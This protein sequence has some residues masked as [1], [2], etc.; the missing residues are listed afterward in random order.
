[1]T[2][3]D[4]GL[5]VGVR[6]L[7]WTMGYSTRLD[8][9]LRGFAPPAAGDRQRA[10]PAES[11]TDLDVLGVAV[12]P[13]Q[14]VATAIADCKTTR[15]DSTSRMFWVRGVADLF[16][17]DHA[18]LVR[19]HDVS[20]AARQLSSRLGIT[21]LPTDDLARLQAFHPGPAADGPPSVLFDR[22]AVERH[23]AAFDALDR[24]LRRLLDYRQFDYWVY[25]PHRNPVQ[26]VAHLAGAARHLDPKNPVHAALFLDLAWLYLLA[27]I[28]VTGHVRGAFLGDPDRGLQEY[29][30][31]G[32]TGLR[33][34]EQTARLFKAMMPDGGEGLDH[35]P[36][37]YGQ[38]RELVV[39][40]LRRP[41]QM[42]DALRYA[43]T[44]AALAAARSRTPL[45]DVFGES[46]DPVAAK[47]VADVCG[48]L[49]A[50]AEL[51]HGF[52]VRARG[53][54]LGEAVP[55]DGPGPAA[56]GSTGQGGAPPV[57]AVPRSPEAGRPSAAGLLAD[58][59]GRL[60]PGGWLAV[61]G[62]PDLPGAAQPLGPSQAVEWLRSA[63][64]ALP[65]QPFAPPSASV[66]RGRVVLGDSADG[67]ASGD[68]RIELL[69]DGS[70]YAAV[71]LVDAPTDGLPALFPHEQVE[72]WLVQLVGLAAAH[73]SAAGAAGPV[74]AA[75]GVVVAPAGGAGAALA[76]DGRAVPGSRPVP[77]PSPAVALLEA[78]PSW[79]SGRS[80]L[81][82][83]AALAADVAAEFGV[84]LPAVLRRDG[85]VDADAASPASARL[86]AWAG[87]A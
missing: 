41:A 15:R 4:L 72:N 70:C 16:G 69:P 43:E 51:H 66:D 55:P 27:L 24:R 23:L 50:A 11:F 49:V 60:L 40:L 57:T 9:Q 22:K 44:A 67:G 31:G 68:W 73:A 47:L 54:L 35:L 64:A 34:K 29:L 17:A 79:Q 63:Q 42:Q 3:L 52:R 14:H 83:A 62:V 36:P 75:A 32:A 74:R 58:G 84:P 59:S 30:F 81:G 71:R 10:R 87:G 2:E 61:A 39:R 1:V 6:R 20:D 37:Y 21:V 8:V 18:Y 80:V 12:N 25:E 26:L 78:G 5:K 33:E 65:A 77:V 85:T 45:Q 48:F 7:L 28:R 19:E 13:G 82:C 56:T 53:F 38:L 86:V 46:F 76:A